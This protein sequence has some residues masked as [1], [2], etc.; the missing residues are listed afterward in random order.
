MDKIILANEQ[1]T[2]LTPATVM[3]AVEQARRAEIGTQHAKITDQIDSLCV[4]LAT[5]EAMLEQVVVADGENGVGLEQQIQQEEFEQRKKQALLQALGSVGLHEGETRAAEYIRYHDLDGS[6]SYDSYH[7]DR[8]SRGLGVYVIDHTSSRQRQRQRPQ[9]LSRTIIGDELSRPVTV[10]SRCDP[11][12][13]SHKT[14]EH[15]VMDTIAILRRAQLRLDVEELFDQ[16]PVAAVVVEY[17]N[18][19]RRRVRRYEKTD[20]E[21]EIFGVVMEAYDDLSDSMPY[22][23]QIRL[24]RKFTESKP[25][26]YVLNAHELRDTYADRDIGFGEMV[27]ANL[28]QQQQ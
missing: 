20:T 10:W 12:Q 27:L 17:N 3:V 22:V 24:Y 19:A 13:V 4:E 9:S 25:D 28:K 18:R 21:G 8:I 15:E 11:H 6:G 16:L 2:R 1:G 23:S 5:L 14:I 7:T 26:S